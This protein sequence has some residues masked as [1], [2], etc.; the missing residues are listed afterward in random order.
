MFMSGPIDWHLI[1]PVKS[2]YVHPVAWNSHKRD[3]KTNLSFYTRP[4]TTPAE[5]FWR[6]S[7]TCW[8]QADLIL[9]QERD[10]TINTILMCVPHEWSLSREAFSLGV[11][12]HS[13][14]TNADQTPETV[15]NQRYKS[16]FSLSFRLLSMPDGKSHTQQFNNMSLV[17]SIVCH[18]F[19]GLCLSIECFFC[20]IQWA[21]TAFWSLGQGQHGLHGS[22]WYRTM[23][24]HCWHWL[25]LYNPLMQGD[26]LQ[27]FF[28]ATL[29]VLS[30]SHDALLN[31]KKTQD[32]I[33][34]W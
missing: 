24:K 25:Y 8:K 4:S 17:A 5:L 22:I 32:A 11:F 13:R 9:C 34:K 3:A 15:I 23:L 16:T 1:W 20:H 27:H 6:S 33:I 21:P 29:H 7:S 31:L 2:F 19:P 26:D 14:Y 28:K 12:I 30:S 10:E 18:R